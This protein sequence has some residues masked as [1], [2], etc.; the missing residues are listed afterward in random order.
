MLPSRSI[1]IAFLFIV[2]GVLRI[3]AQNQQVVIRFQLSGGQPAE[4]ATVQLKP[5]SAGGAATTWLTNMQ[6][7]VILRADGIRYA[8]SAAFTG[9]E[10]I[11]DTLTA[12]GKADTIHY[13]FRQHFTELAGVEIR[14]RKKILEARD[15]RYIYNVSADSSARSKSL[16]QILSNLPF[17]TVDGSGNVQVAG[18]TT[19]KVL[20]NGKE[21]ALFVTSVAQALRSFPA[22]IV[23]RIELITSPSARYDAEGV[24]AIIN[25][26]TKK[27]AGYKGFSFAYVSDRAQY[28][29]GLT[30]TGRTGKLGITLNGDAN[31]NWNMLKG[32]T[33][34][35]THPWQ[36]S[37][38]EERTVSGK[39]GN[40]KMSVSG[41][42]ELNYEIDSLHSLIGYITAGKD[43]VNEALRQ[44]VHTL[45]PGNNSAQGFI[46]MNSTDRSPSLT[47]GLDYTQK[48]KKNAAKELAFRFNWKGT[49]NTLHNSTTQEYDAFSKWMINHSAARNDEYTFQLDAIPMALKKYTM[50]VGIK[51]ILR[52]ASADYTSLFAFDN[53]NEYEKDPRNSNSF[54]YRQ[55]VYA[56]YGSVSARL[57]KN[58]LRAGVRLEQTNIKGYFSNLP[59]PVN[60]NYL[61]VI[62]NFYWSLKTGQSTATSL[63]Y[64]LNLQRPYITNLNPYVNN[65]D[66]FNINYGNPD[67]GPQQ[68]HKLVAQFRYSKEKLFATATLTGT[69]SND[70]I[71]LYRLFEPATGITATT[72]GNV[73]KEQLISLGVS[74]WHQIHKTFQ[75]GFGAELRYVDV[76]NRL[77][78]GQHTYGYSGIVSG[79]FRWDAGKRINLSGSGG[80][81]VSNVTLLGRKSPYYFY[82]A[83]FGYHIVK[84]K[85]FATI[86]WNNV[87]ASYFTQRTF[88]AD[89]AVS[90]VTTTKRVYRMI[91]LG[92]QYTFGK[93][94]QEVTRKK[95][96]VN[97][98]ILR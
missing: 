25:I 96:V 50:E 84:N 83:N 62:P 35:V 19:Y 57:K 36:A 8:L 33:T 44:D 92:I 65:T 16:S 41:T 10:M 5:L 27:F 21:T 20:L 93:L 9:M 56:A 11:T 47:A 15:D 97:D 95:G 66:S 60:D 29:D 55:Q 61:S 32:Y 67:L 39:N 52:Q 86:N 18:Q 80:R 53:N 75:A 42:L 69:W 6:G 49:R 76:R 4:N 14:S 73:G 98:D 85:L 64:N 89:D 81:D 22:D 7:I 23:S 1:L 38:Y 78:P 28:S 26:I 54:N 45:L 87:H 24:T 77:Q 46:A 51:T 90:S 74:I 34:T 79:Y 63:S 30:L 72:F 2:A 13:T 31:G 94:R 59:D 37:A 43:A 58:N 68:I 70:R 88:F 40:R 91:Y 82:Q 17:V 3:N 12:D 71:L 48:S